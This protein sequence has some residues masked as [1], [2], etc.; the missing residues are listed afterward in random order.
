MC[1]DSL[2][3]CCRRRCFVSWLLI[4]SNP[5][6]KYIILSFIQSNSLKSYSYSIQRHVCCMFIYCV[7]ISVRNG[8][9][10]DCYRDQFDQFVHAVLQPPWKWVTCPTSIRNDNYLTTTTTI[11]WSGSHLNQSNTRGYKRNWSSLRVF[12][13]SFLSFF[14]W[15]WIV[16]AMYNTIG[17]A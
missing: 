7:F 3:V 9:I 11:E 15:L 2:Q 1:G 17:D 13:F 12:C 8:N 16:V 10:S 6:P 14:L 4:N 5:T